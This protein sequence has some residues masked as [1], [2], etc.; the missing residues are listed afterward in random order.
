MKIW[1]Y[2]LSMISASGSNNHTIRN[3]E[4]FNE[5]KKELLLGWLNQI[6]SFL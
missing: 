1:N 6:S 2:K 5:N 3:W 4:V